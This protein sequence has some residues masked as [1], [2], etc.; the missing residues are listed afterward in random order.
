MEHETIQ[1]IAAIFVALL[2]NVSVG[3]F[4]WN[5]FKELKSLKKEIKEHRKQKE[6]RHRKKEQLYADLEL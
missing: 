2:V 6:E 5:H 3:L 1:W 4:G